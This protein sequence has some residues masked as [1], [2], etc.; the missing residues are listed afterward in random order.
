MNF[1]QR[2]LTYWLLGVILSKQGVAELATAK[3]VRGLTNTVLLEKIIADSG[4][5]KGYIAKVLGIRVETLG[6]KIRNI[7]YFTAREI[8][9]LCDVLSIYDSELKESIFYCRQVAE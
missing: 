4:Y 1:F 7:S 5:K 2:G 6:R 8:D 9:L 3:E